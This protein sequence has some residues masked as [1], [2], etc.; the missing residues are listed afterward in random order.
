MT[1]LTRPWPTLGPGLRRRSKVDFWTGLI[2]VFLLSSIA[3]SLGR[4]ARK[5]DPQPTFDFGRVFE[6]LTRRPEEPKSKKIDLHARLMELEAKKDNTPY[7]A[8]QWK[9]AHGRGK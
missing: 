7:Y 2:V 5:A 1:I 3:T 9:A 6:G 8:K 4:M